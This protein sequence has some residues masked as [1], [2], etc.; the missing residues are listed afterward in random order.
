[1][2]NYEVNLVAAALVECCN[3]ECENMGINTETFGAF[4]SMSDDCQ[5]V[6]LWRYTTVLADGVPYQD[7]L[8]DVRGG[9]TIF[10]HTI[11]EFGIELTE[12]QKSVFQEFEPKFAVI[13]RI[14][15]VQNKIES[16]KEE[17]QF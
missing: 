8:D 4:T 16:L 14:Q 1:M 15:H 13:R 11:D 10:E 3:S 7:F 2:G 6:I 9:E 5:L 17:I 12:N